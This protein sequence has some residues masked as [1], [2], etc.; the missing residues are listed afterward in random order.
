M[1]KMKTNA[2]GISTSYL[3]GAPLGLIAIC[4]VF[5]IPALL[6]GEGLALFAMAMIYGKAI[7]GLVISFLIALGI[8]GHYAVSDLESGRTLIKTS[9]RYS[10]TV[11]AIIWLVFMIL[12]ILDNTKDFIM[13]LLP[14]L[15]AF[16]FCTLSTTFTLGLLICYMIKKKIGPAT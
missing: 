6:T 3:I 4:F 16:L 5:L 1:F 8:A 10:I 2:K 12:T 15:I 9:F 11:N 14:P 13:L 7:V